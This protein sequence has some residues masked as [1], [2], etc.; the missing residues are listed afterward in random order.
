MELYYSITSPYARKVRV[1]IHEIGLND[2]VNLTLCNPFADVEKLQ[3]VNPLRKI[4]ALVLDDGN[5]LYDSPVICEYLDSLDNQISTVPIAGIA[6]FNVLR[7]QAIADGI[8]DAA[9]SIVME[10]R[11]TDAERSNNWITRWTTAINASLDIL[12]TDIL[13]CSDPVNIG[14]IAI[15]C[16]LGYLDFRLADLHWRT[17]RVKLATWF[18]LFATRES[19]KITNPID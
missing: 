19:M 13:T 12:E 17:D 7:Q 4:P 5:S 16:A 10:I 2:R 9:I 14:Q 1:L 18:D 8:M 3:Q 11:R 6:R 15:G